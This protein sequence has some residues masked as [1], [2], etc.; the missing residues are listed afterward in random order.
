MKFVW[1]DLK[2]QK[3]FCVWKISHQ[4]SS[5]LPGEKSPFFEYCVNGKVD[6]NYK[7]S[8]T[9][10]KKTNHFEECYNL[11]NRI[12]ASKFFFPPPIL[13]LPNVLSQCHH[14]LSD[15]LQIWSSTESQNLTRKLAFS[16]KFIHFFSYLPKISS[17]SQLNSNFHK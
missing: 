9:W 11:K 12:L 6:F 14:L 17:C 2:K 7:G 13:K 10:A 1:Q 8:F 5:F 16:E 3:Y 4:I 15:K